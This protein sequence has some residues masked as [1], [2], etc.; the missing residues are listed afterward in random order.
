LELSDKQKMFEKVVGMETAKLMGL[1]FDCVCGQ[2][3]RIPIKHLSM[4]P[5]AVA[6]VK[7]RLRKLGISGKGAVVYDKKIESIV[8]DPVLARLKKGGLSLERYPVGDGFEI[9]PPEIELS[10]KIADRIA[11]A[12]GGGGVKGGVDYLVSIGSGVVSDL[13]KYAAS[14]IEKPFILLATAPSMNGYTSSMAALTDRAIKKT[15]M[16]LPAHG[17]FADYGILMKSPVE[18]VRSGLGDIL[19]K[20]ICNADWKLSELVKNTYYC[21]LSFRITDKSEPIYLD[22]AEEIGART[23]QG[24]AALTD[25]IMRSGLSMT[26]IGTSTPSSGAEHFL[27]HYWD[28]IALIEHKAKNFHGVQVGVATIIILKLYDFIRNYPVKQSIDLEKLKQNYP[29]EA[30]VRSFIERRFGLYAAGVRE[31]FLKKYLGW[32]EKKQEIEGILDRWGS[33]WNELSPYI[34]TVKPIE[35]ALRKSGAAHTFAHLGKTR[36]E[37][38]D[39]LRNATLIR[40]R[41]TILD[42]A[43][44]LG[45]MEK[46][47]ETIL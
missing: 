40:G 9:L 41:Y 1:E 25:G 10:K 3:H 36:D 13:V 12:P 37:V 27:S 23:E 38:I 45:I 22:A 35:E 2:T 32:R 17:V 29:T 30:D 42:L 44:D 18:L 20:S 11:A 8:V 16:I 6:D 5:D 26:V 19:S 47:V 15:L 21:S 43:N 14:L 4:K 31:E 33:I 7:D 46:A 28:L 39:S 24:I 34:R